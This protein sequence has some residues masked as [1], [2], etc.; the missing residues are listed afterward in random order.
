MSCKVET[1]E[2]EEINTSNIVQQTSFWAHVKYNQGMEPYA[3]K[4]IASDDLLF[5]ARRGLGKI[6]D[7]ILVLVR[8]V[9]NDSCIAY[10]PYGPRLEPD[11]ENHGV[12]LEELSEV[13]RTYLPQNCILIRYDLPWE[14]QWAKEDDFY[15]DKG[16]WNGP[17]TFK[18]QEYRVNF[19]T[20]NWNLH[21]SQSDLLPSNTIFLNLKQN[22]E[23]LLKNMKPKTRY[24]IRLSLRKGV[25]VQ[26]Y[27]MDKLSIWYSLYK[28]T[29]KR[30][31]ITLHDIDFFHSVLM[32]QK[33]NQEGDVGAR[34]IMADY[35]GE[36]L[37][38]MFLILSKKRGSYLYGASS[39]KKRNLMASYAVQWEAINIAKQAGC[40]EYDMFGVA[41][42]TNQSHP[43][44]GLYRFKSGFGG[45][46]F[47]RMGCWDYP[48]NNEAYFI[49]RAQELKNET[50]HI[51]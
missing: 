44:H 28:D 51:N 31:N 11:S 9:N 46:L 37:A 41:P 27:G 36:Y 21:K 18:H 38:A 20:N 7:D 3:F 34:L 29:A 32:N 5:P 13:L 39:G 30:N 15:D 48:L 22:K 14:N 45:N 12:F 19:N 26:T 35:E 10:V 4:F 24:N 6:Q 40:E 47:H 8:Y 2:I 42:N 43:L 16:N 49:F 23:N 17:P 1:K 50:Y 25:N 33:K